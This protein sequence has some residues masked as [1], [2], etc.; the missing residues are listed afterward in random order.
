MHTV[1]SIAKVGKPN[2][3]KSVKAVTDYFRKVDKARYEYQ[4]LGQMIEVD[5][6]VTKEKEESS[7][8][9]QEN[10]KNVQETKKKFA[11]ERS[12]RKRKQKA[13]YM[14]N[15]RKKLKSNTECA[16]SIGESNQEVAEESECITIEEVNDMI[17]DLTG[18]DDGGDE[19]ET[20]EVI[21]VKS[22]KRRPDTWRNVV[23]HFQIFEDVSSTINAFQQELSHL[24]TWEAKR[25]TVYR[26][27]SDFEKVNSQNGKRIG[28]A[29]V[30]GRELDTLVYDCMVQ[31]ISA[32]LTCDNHILRETIK[33]ELVKQNLSSMLKENGGKYTFG[34]NWCFRFW[35]RHNLSSRIA[36]TKMR[37]LP[38]DF[39]QKVATY[40]DI[41]S[42]LIAQYN[43]P[44]ELVVGC[45]ETN[46]QQNR[47]CGG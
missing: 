37:E 7:L 27:K 19:A 44:K 11:A 34:T 2:E 29:P 47:D 5:E 6:R 28:H 35:K 43:I 25:A 36:T 8:R 32:G 39:E 1:L 16:T 26:W 14:R 23:R 13:A 22:W 10:W 15:Y 38:D 42:K 30:Y 3:E 41:G 21:P 33:N 24:N 4:M 45:D 12:A 40:V 46:V 9:Q 31:R 18:K 17:N 20:D